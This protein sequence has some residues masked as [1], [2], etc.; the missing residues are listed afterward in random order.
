M[1]S[2][3]FYNDSK[4]QISFSYNNDHHD[5][6]D[7]SPYVSVDDID[8][9]LID[10]GYLSFPDD[11]E[12][13]LDAYHEIHPRPDTNKKPRRMWIRRQSSSG[14]SLWQLSARTHKRL[15]IQS[16]SEYPAELHQRTITLVYFVNTFVSPAYRKLMKGQL[17]D[18]AKSGFLE[19]PR[20]RLVVV[21]LG[22]L[23]ESHTVV[24]LIR[25]SFPEQTSTSA[26]QQNTLFRVQHVHYDENTYEFRGIQ[27]AWI[28]GMTSSNPLDII[29][30]IHNKG[31]SHTEPLQPKRL[32]KEERLT[33]EIACMWPRNLD[34][35]CSIP[36]L[37]R[38]AF[39]IGGWGWG[40]YNFWAATA[41][42]LQ[43]VEMP[44]MTDRRHYYEDWLARS[45]NCL[46]PGST[47]RPQ[48]ETRFHVEGI[49]T[50]HQNA[51]F[52]ASIGLPY[53]CPF[54]AIGDIIDPILSDYFFH[55]KDD[56]INYMYA[57]KP[58]PAAAEPAK[59]H[60]DQPAATPAAPEA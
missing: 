5:H 32:P 45:V 22:E 47:L 33:K 3:G 34:I 55:E 29:I 36:S 44:L 40:W 21:S 38:L 27:Q 2:T 31:V 16:K 51:D 13:I 11:F 43:S 7:D 37:D 25:R 1:D 26:D 15:K 12:S 9:T 4:L 14:L 6:D 59:P 41:G 50:Y 46:H 17:N 60:T 24:S 39:T 10:Q 52:C 18:I 8:C 58:R 42:Y 19:S 23:D 56:W 30:Y 49:E 57:N 48:Q 20:N 53:G 28:A 35:L 54:A